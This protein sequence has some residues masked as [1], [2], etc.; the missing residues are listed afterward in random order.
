MASATLVGDLPPT[1]SAPGAANTSSNTQ[2][3][4]INIGTRRSALAQ[5]QARSVELALKKAHPERTYNICPVLAQGDKDKI[6]PLQQLSQGENAKS[7]WTGELESMLEQ[8]ELDLIVH[9]LKDMPTQLP[10]NLDLAAILEREDPRDALVVS[11][12]LPKDTTIATLPEGSTIGTSSVRRAAQ[13]RRLYPS[14]KFADLRGNVGTR[15][16]KLDAEDSP[17]NAIILAAAGL[18]R[19]GMDNRI[20]QYLSSDSGGMLHAVGQ[21][22]LAIE[23]RK[24]DEEIKKILNKI[25]D[26]RTTRACSAERAL[27]RTLEGGCSVPIGVETSWRGGKG[28]TVGAQPAKDYDKHGDAIEEE[29]DLDEQELVLKT[30]VV[31]VDGKESVSY[32]VARKV[33]SVEDAQTLGRE[34][35]KI[36]VD[37]GADK[38]LEQIS[39]DK[40]WAAKKELEAATAAP[41]STS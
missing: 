27:L 1:G 12:R 24:D 5:I 35:A 6:T 33:R 9:C 18:K 40:Q 11:P 4:P 29:V 32:E 17:F 38:I 2:F 22:A 14:F 34:V 26:E 10:D 3:P 19:L 37:K 25:G 7:L 13:L 21:G 30:L 41:A 23:I 39:R 8:G 16:G 20:N 31:S 36:L 28:L 15:L